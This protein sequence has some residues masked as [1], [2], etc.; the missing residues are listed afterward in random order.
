MNR[1]LLVLLAT[2]AAVAASAP[3]LLAHCQIPCGIYDDPVRFALLRE[4]VTTIEKS[5]S[6]INELSQQQPANWNQIV[7][8]VVNKEEHADQLCEI[9]TFYFMTQRVKPADPAD[10]AAQAKYVKQ[11]TL[12]HQMLVEAMKAKQT[13]DLEHCQNLRA[14][15]DQFEAVYMGKEAAATV[16]TDGSVAHT[17]GPDTHTH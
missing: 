3:M 8:W 17:H 10:A 6:Q 11:V 9:V 16:P 12:L 1:K 14:L 2:L 13:T 5:I 15:I 7:R 4:H